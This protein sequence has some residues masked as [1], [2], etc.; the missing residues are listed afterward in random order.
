MTRHG[1]LVYTPH[2]GPQSTPPKPSKTQHFSR[3]PLQKSQLT[4]M[5]IRKSKLKILN[6]IN[7]TPYHKKKE[8]YFWLVF[9]IQKDYYFLSENK[10]SHY[11]CGESVIF[12][13]YGPGS[14]KIMRLWPDPDLQRY[15]LC[16]K[17]IY[18]YNYTYVC[19]IG[20]ILKLLII[21]HA[22]LGYFQ[23]I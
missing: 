17:Y 9:L 10:F 20:S 11:V 4:W 1:V 8:K 5:H 2:S 23:I 13:E 18:I 22:Q 14:D 7:S 19:R 12:G 15:S 3:N 6:K 21:L 16:W